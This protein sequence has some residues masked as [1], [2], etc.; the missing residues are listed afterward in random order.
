MSSESDQPRPAPGSV[1]PGSSAALDA[2]GTVRRHPEWFF[3]DGQ[4]DANELARLLADEALKSG[5][6]TVTI[7]RVG[8]WFSVEA[9]KDWLQGDLAA[10]FAP[11]SFAGGGRNSSRVEVALTAF[12]RAVVTV[13]REGPYEVYSSPGSTSDIADIQ[14]PRVVEGRAVAF[15][16]PI[17]QPGVE[18]VGLTEPDLHPRL[19]LVQGEGERLIASAVARFVDKRQEILNG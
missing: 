15:L 11:L 4:V 6:G 1:G 10:F 18:Q 3:K 5:A 13:S 2:V 7:R 17:G 16:A 14:L 9:D 19:R 8:Q 12:C